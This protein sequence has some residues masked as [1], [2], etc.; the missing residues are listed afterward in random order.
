ME[1]EGLDHSSWGQLVV[2]YYRGR[3]FGDILEGGGIFVHHKFAKDAIHLRHNDSDQG[4]LSR[5]PNYAARRVRGTFSGGTF[6]NARCFIMRI[7]ELK[8]LY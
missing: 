8:C 2:L 1:E 7:M 6:H 4:Y 5:V 3:L